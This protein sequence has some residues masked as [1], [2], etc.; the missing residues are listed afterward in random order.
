MGG[1]GGTGPAASV[2][3][4]FRQGM[5]AFRHRDFRIFFIGAI[6]SNSGSWLQNLAVPFVLFELT[7]KAIWV[8]LAGFAQFIPSFVLGPIGGTLADGNDRRKVLLAT[9]SAMAGAA[10]M[11]WG[12]W[13]LDWREP[14]LILAIVALTGVF[15]GLNIPSWQAFVPAL[16]PREDLA[17]AITLN[18]TQFN[19][20]RAIGPA[21]AGVLLAVAGPAWA[22]F[23]NGLSFIAVLVALSMVR[24]LPTERK[25]GFA[26]K[27]V[28]SGFREGLN[29]INRR[30]GIR[31]SIVCAMLVAFFGNPI[32]QFTVVFVSDVYDAGP[33]VLGVLAAAV[34]VGA[35]MIAPMLSTWDGVV[36]RS[37]L[38]RWALPG[39]AIAVIAFGLAPVWPL[40][41]IA[42]LFVGA[43]FLVVIATTNTAVQ[44]IVA[45]EMRG[46][47]MSVR[48]MGF[49]L[50]FPVGSL[51]QGALGDVWG[52]QLTVVLSGSILLVVALWM[53]TQPTLLDH[54]D[55]LDDTPNR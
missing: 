37:A 24:A 50:A 43:G 35:V 40:G 4:G 20:A 47:V 19:A 39:Y 13:V 1:P 55:A 21:L 14:V 38:V 3:T 32:T 6:I 49:T 53:W 12:A 29:Y 7:G 31:V 26:K 27:S 30:T 11:L 15:A 54:L 52:P 25:P 51:V 36:T 46:R 41:L 2:P 22:F 23:L 28:A 44:M 33:R 16:V 48:V 9:Q 5:R 8:G 10:F 18:S 45:D 17:S 34:G 42:L